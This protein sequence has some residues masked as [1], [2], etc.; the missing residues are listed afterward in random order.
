MGSEETSVL[1]KWVLSG[2]V[3][4]MMGKKVEPSTEGKREHIMNGLYLDS[5]LFNPE[6]PKA[7]YFQSFTHSWIHSHA[8]GGK[9]DLPHVVAIKCH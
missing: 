1:K 4:V 9:L 7:L 6:D 2:F 5:A 3:Q 8:D